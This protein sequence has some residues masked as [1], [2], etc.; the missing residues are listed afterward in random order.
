L[1]R[2]GSIEA[3]SKGQAIEQATS[4]SAKECFSGNNLFRAASFRPKKGIDFKVIVEAGDNY[5]ET[6]GDDAKELAQTPLAAEI[7]AAVERHEESLDVVLG[8]MRSAQLPGT[9]VIDGALNQMRAIRRGNDENAILSFNASHKNIK[10]AI[11]R[12]ADLATALTDNAVNDIYKARS[13]AAILPILVEE[14]DLNPA[15]VE[16]GA[17]LDD[18]LKRETFFREFGPIAKSA[19]EIQGEYKRRYDVALDGRVKAYLDALETLAK[20]PG[21]ERLDDGQREE[22]SQ[23]LRQCADKNWNNQTI[24]HLRSETELCETR[25]AAAIAKMHQILDGERLV[26]VSVGQYFAGG[27]ETEEQLDQ[28]LGGIRDEFSRLIGE[29]KKVIVK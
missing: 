21:W 25:L 17:L 16:E 27:I 10:A 6:F 4:T 23:Q 22:I 1:L 20:A 14:P 9:D 19:A 15:F 3:I 8:I 13:A 29:G 11:K 28:A 12:G 7:R 5:R 26:T 24:R 18:L 2:A